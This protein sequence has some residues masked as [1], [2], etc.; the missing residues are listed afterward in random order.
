MLRGR[1]DALHCGDD[2]TVSAS[3]GRKNAFT[4]R[5]A[6]R[7]TDYLLVLRRL[8][9]LLQ[10]EVFPILSRKK[11][12]APGQGRSTDRTRFDA[13]NSIWKMSHSLRTLPMC[14]LTNRPWSRMCA[15][16]LHREIKGFAMDRVETGFVVMA[17]TGFMVLLG[18]VAAM[19]VM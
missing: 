14:R 13:G 15:M 5:G 18:A 7:P 3:N 16:M 9:K 19:A 8:L 10:G 6:R 2:G 12:T 11:R 17:L 1:E 4:P